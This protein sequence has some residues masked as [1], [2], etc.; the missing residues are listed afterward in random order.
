MKIS[1]LYSFLKNNKKQNKIKSHSSRN[2]PD[3]LAV[4]RRSE[5]KV[6]LK[7]FILFFLKLYSDHVGAYR[8]VSLFFIVL[9]LL[10]SI[11]G[12]LLLSNS[13]PDIHGHAIVILVFPKVSSY[14]VTGT[15]EVILFS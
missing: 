14:L 2:F 6:K 8:K 4:F 10:L 3:Y 11:L 15:H 1:N 12:S 13:G 7:L 9:Y 5:N